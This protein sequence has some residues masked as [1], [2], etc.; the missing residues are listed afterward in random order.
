MRITRRRFLAGLGTTGAA[1]GADAFGLEANRVLLTRH[2]VRVPGLPSALDGIRIAQVT[3][4]HFP[5]NRMA[6]R[7][8]LAHVRRERPEVVVLNGDMLETIDAADR[9]REFAAQVR[10]SLATVSI[11]GNWEY[12]AGVTG[13]VAQE[14]YQGTGVELLLNRSRI[15]PLGSSALALVGLDDVLMGKPDLA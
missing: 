4:V 6:A 13:R 3:D 15:V 2:E 12:R 14:L 9:V 1:L 8:A 5:G 11:L 7:A 10:G